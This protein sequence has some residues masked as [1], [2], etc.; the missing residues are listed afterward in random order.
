MNIVIE[1]HFFK[2]E[3]KVFLLQADSQGFFQEGLGVF[4]EEMGLLKLQGIL[5]FY[6]YNIEENPA[7]AFLQAKFS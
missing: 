1:G 2:Q 7:G 5:I 4:L 3:V 6:L